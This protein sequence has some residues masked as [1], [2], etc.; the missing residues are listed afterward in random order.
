MARISHPAAGGLARVPGNKPKLRDKEYLNLSTYKKFNNNHIINIEK[1]SNER[2]FFVEIGPH[3]LKVKIKN[4]I[5]D[6]TD[7]LGATLCRR[8]YGDVLTHKCWSFVEHDKHNLCLVRLLENGGEEG[9]A[10][11]FAVFYYN[12]KYNIFNK[13]EG[14]T[15]Y[16]ED[17]E[18]KRKLKKII[19]KKDYLFFDRDDY[20]EYQLFELFL[21]DNKTLIFSPY[22]LWVGNE[23]MGNDKWLAKEVQ[24]VITTKTGDYL[25]VF[26]TRFDKSP[27]WISNNDDKAEPVMINDEEIVMILRNCEHLNWFKLNDDDVLILAD[28]EWESYLIIL[29]YREDGSFEFNLLQYYCPRGTRFPSNFAIMTENMVNKNYMESIVFI[30]NYKTLRDDEEYVV[31]NEYRANFLYSLSFDIFGGLKRN[32]YKYAQLKERYDCLVQGYIKIEERLL[33]NQRL[34]IP[35]YLRMQIK[36]FLTKLT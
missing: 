29:H 25:M 14:N 12:Y 20:A 16:D 3:G 11:K 24:G 6:S 15:E 36:S 9:A 35:Y 23:L 13:F 21:K 27:V 33:K 1:V 32:S 30:G 19:F 10:E 8:A 2:I 34:F 22:E 18:H 7:D 17:L 5:D 28:G 26:C 31:E 4:G